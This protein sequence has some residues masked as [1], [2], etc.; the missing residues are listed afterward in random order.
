MRRLSSVTTLHSTWT[1][2]TQMHGRKKANSLKN[3]SNY[4]EDA[5][6]FFDAALKLDPDHKR[7]WFNKGL[8]LNCLNKYEE[9]I[10]CYDAALNL[11]SKYTDA[12]IAIG[13]SLKNLS[14]YENSFSC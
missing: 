1:L 2:N 8:S 5:N 11:D 6:S 10:V 7:A 9:A 3:L 14:K 4:Y 12:W 13:I